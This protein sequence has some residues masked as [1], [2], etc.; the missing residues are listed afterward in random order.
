MFVGGY[1]IH[2]SQLL[3][4]LFSR[5]MLGLGFGI[6]NCSS[7]LVASVCGTNALLPKIHK[8]PPEDGFKS[9]ISPN[10]SELWNKPSLQMRCAVC[11][12][13]QYCVMNGKSALLIVCHMPE[14]TS[15]NL[16]HR[17][18]MSGRQ[19]RVNCKLVMTVCEGTF[20]TSLADSCSSCLNWWWSRQ[21]LEIVCSCSTS[22]FAN[23]KCR[24]SHL[25]ACPPCHG[26]TLLL[27]REVFFAIPVIFLLSN[28]NTWYKHFLKLVSKWYGFVNSHI[29]QNFVSQKIH[30]LPSFQ[31]L[32]WFH[33]HVLTAEITIVYEARTYF[34]I[35]IFA[36][37]SSDQAFS[38]VGGHC[39]SCL[40]I[41]PW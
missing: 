6:K 13:W 15:W 1:V 10:K 29:F 16:V 5:Y 41:T 18:K 12:T 27:V 3:N 21:G 8:T 20:D 7:F 37:P 2:L 23:S 31:T 35:G 14:S 30:I 9:S 38:T 25:W 28:R 32:F 40:S 4:L 34:Q 33:P 22:L 11:S 39:I 19:T 24:S 26:T 36:P 17:S